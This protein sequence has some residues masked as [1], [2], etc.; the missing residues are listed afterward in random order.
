M[1]P[2]HRPSPEA[3]N[4]LMKRLCLLLNY[5]LDIGMIASAPMTVMKGNQSDGEGYHD[6]TGQLIAQFIARHLLGATTYLALML[7]HSTGQ[8]RSDVVRTG[9]GDIAIGTIQARQQM[10]G[11]PLMIPIIPALQTALSYLPQ[12][13]PTCLMAEHR[14][15]PRW[16]ASES[17]GGT[18]ATSWGLS[19]CV[20]HGLRKAF[21]RSLAE[22]GCT[23]H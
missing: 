22:A 14:S 12:D 8:G 20:S 21:A 2:T 17:G 4:T 13:A 18:A 7:M 9:W 1:R 19:N 16:L 3:A 11:T 15:P 10:T 6:R 5:A 23:H